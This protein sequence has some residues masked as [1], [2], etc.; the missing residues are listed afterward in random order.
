VLDLIGA[1]EADAPRSPAQMAFTS[2]VAPPP[3]LAAAL[4]RFG[5]V[6]ADAAASAAARLP[7]RP[8]HEY[9]R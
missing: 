1:A 6:V 4:G 2:G 3:P 7:D 8:I 9:S 5:L